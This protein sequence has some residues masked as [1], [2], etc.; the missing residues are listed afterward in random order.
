M[1]LTPPV[2]SVPC[3]HG[4]HPEHTITLAPTISMAGGI[5]AEK[6]MLEVAQADH[7][8]N[9]ARIRALT[10]AW[11]PI[12]ARH[13]A[14]DWDLCDESG[15]PLPFDVEAILADYSLARLVADKAGDLG[16]GTAVMAPFE[17]K[18]A[19]PSRPSRIRATT[20]APVEP[21]PPPSE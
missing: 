12:F 7:A 20:S 18:P 13:A 4:H 3:K 10:Y 14:I 2:V 19:K 8:D 9:V 5:E 16:Y 15:D 17:S 1:S 11:A 21:T 6:A